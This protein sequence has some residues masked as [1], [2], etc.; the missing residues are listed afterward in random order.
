MW[1][2][3]AEATTAVYYEKCY[4]RVQHMNTEALQ[5]ENFTTT[6]LSLLRCDSVAVVVCRHCEAACFAHA[7]QTTL[8]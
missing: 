4:R 8:Q 7:Q 2:Y 1:H 3:Y 5:T 6:T